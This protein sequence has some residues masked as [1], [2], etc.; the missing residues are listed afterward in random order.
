MKKLF[1]LLLIAG[2]VFACNQMQDDDLGASPQPSFKVYFCDSGGN[3]LCSHLPIDLDT[4]F[5][6]RQGYESFLDSIRQPPLD[7]FSWQ[8]FVA[9]NWPSND[10]GQPI[11]GSISDNPGAMRV[12]EH[13]RD[14]ASVFRGGS[15]LLGASTQPL[16]LHL[17][18]AAGKKLKFFYMDSKSPQA[19]DSVTGFKEADGHPLID[20]NLNFAVYEI[21]LNN[22]EDTFITNNNLTTKAG[23]SAYNRVHG[24]TLP[25]GD[26]AT[27]NPGAIEVKASWRILDPAKGDDTT[28]YYCRDAVIFIDSISNVTGKNMVVNAKVGLVGMHIIRK[29][30]TFSDKLIWST[31]EHID[32]APDNPQDAQMHY[33]RLWSF[34]NPFCLN[35]VP[36]DTP[37]FQQGDNGNYRWDSVPPYASRYAVNAP[38]Q[39][40]STYGTQVMRTFPIY[41]YTEQMNNLW[42]AK[43]KGTIWANYRLVGTQWQGGENYPPTNAPAL[44]ANTTLETYI[45]PTATC[46]G[47]HGN[48]GIRVAKDS[49][50][51][52]TDFSFIFPVYAK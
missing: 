14:P 39:P 44:L 12:W 46:I 5:D 28:R 1:V 19:L 4:N 32:N 17:S 42:R 15:E 37:V 27:G 13:F 10:G 43:L 8:T 35:C 36:N 29:T 30:T 2:A 20:R 26:S 51:V 41:K 38:S 40:D 21:R 24:F 7:L 45:Q 23:I 11:G 47:C 34:Y 25:I 31:F 52:R 3:Q 50:K 49:A 48:A 22:V 33:G 9:L 16:L 6:S 18:S